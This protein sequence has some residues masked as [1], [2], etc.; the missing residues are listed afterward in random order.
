MTKVAKPPVTDFG[1]LFRNSVFLIVMSL[2]L[3]MLGMILTVAVGRQYLQK[4]LGQYSFLV[5]L[6]FVACAAMDFG[7]SARAVR[8]FARDRG[9]ITGLF[10]ESLVAK[11]FLTLLTLALSFLL[12]TALH[13]EDVVVLSGGLFLAGSVFISFSNYVRAP[14]DAIQRMEF[15]ALLETGR[16]TITV[17]AGFWALQHG[18]GLVA[19]GAVFAGAAAIQLV[20]WCFLYLRYFPEPIARIELWRVRQIVRAAS[21]FGGIALLGSFFPRLDLIVVS[22]LCGD[23]EAGRLNAALVFFL[24][25]V[26]V[27][28]SLQAAVFPLFSLLRDASQAERAHVY[29]RVHKLLLCGIV[30]VLFGL[31]VLGRP[32]VNLAFGS[33]FDSSATLLVLLNLGLFFH[34][35]A[36][37]A[38]V[39]LRGLD[40][41]SRSFRILLIACSINLA[42]D[43]VLVPVFKSEGAVAG[44]IVTKICW[45]MLSYRALRQLLPGL[46]LAPDMLRIFVAGSP[47]GITLV[48]FRY[49]PLPIL[50][51]LAALSYGLGLL[52]TGA[53]T[54]AELWGIVL[55]LRPAKFKAALKGNVGS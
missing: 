3:R 20:C 16:Q 14:F 15:Q 7:I 26:F 13:Y 35:L 50:V 37:C 19:L 6:S 36:L 43:G 24:F 48:V 30:P 23:V 4:G 8:T 41:E 52:L 40:R 21:S 27:A 22:L 55:K 9:A 5:A 29:E 10:L 49:Y 33:A 46:R 11:G 17:G 18:Y 54:P 34:A 2:V 44:H 39:A 45:A 53:V 32:I 25:F 51:P 42:L 28:G 1:P 31:S 12:L 38:D 47:M